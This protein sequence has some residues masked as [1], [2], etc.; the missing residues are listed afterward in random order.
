MILKKVENWICLILFLVQEHLLLNITSSKATV[1]WA[2]KN[3]PGEHFLIIIMLQP[4]RFW[5]LLWYLCCKFST[6]Y[7]CQCRLFPALLK[8]ILGS[9]IFWLQNLKLLFLMFNNFFPLRRKI[10][11]IWKVTGC[12][13]VTSYFINQPQ[14]TAL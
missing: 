4:R 12:I 2:G 13:C 1:Y 7:E 6:E 11:S 9:D 5:G 10:F 3:Y 14:I 8:G